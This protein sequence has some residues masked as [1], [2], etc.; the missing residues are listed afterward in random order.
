MKYRIHFH[1]IGGASCSTDVKPNGTI[2]ELMAEIY[3]LDIYTISSNNPTVAPH[4]AIQTKNI[5]FLAITELKPEGI[6]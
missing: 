4:L 3:G 6:V 5:A 2:V 1:M